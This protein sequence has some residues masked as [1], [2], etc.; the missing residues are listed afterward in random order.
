MSGRVPYL[1]VAVGAVVLAAVALVL[2]AVLDADWIYFVVIAL[3][4]TAWAASIL[5]Q[6]GRT[7]WV[8]RL[9]AGSWWCRSS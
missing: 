1:L 4:L 2:R 8:W 5:E 9:W 3:L 6:W 7:V